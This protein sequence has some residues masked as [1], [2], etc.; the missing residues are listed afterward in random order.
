MDIQQKRKQYNRKKGIL[1]HMAKWLP[2]SVTY[3]IGGYVQKYYEPFRVGVLRYNKY[4]SFLNRSA[5]WDKD[6]IEAY[7]VKKLRDVLFFVQKHIPY[8]TKLFNQIGF[9]V[10]YIRSV[11]DLERIPLLTKDDIAQHRKSLMAD[12]LTQRE[13]KK[14]RLERSTSGST[15]TPL[16]IYSDKRFFYQR[17]AFVHWRLSRAGI[18]VNSRYI[19]LWS[20]P[21]IMSRSEELCIH[22]PY[23]GKLSLSSVPKS[24]EFY[25]GYLYWIK[26]F[27]PA[28]I[29]GP[30]SFMTS[31]A[32]YAKEKHFKDIHIPVFYS[33]YEMLYSYQENIIKEQ[34]GCEILRYY[35]CEERVVYAFECSYHEG[36]HV[37][38]RR[39]FVEIV[40][41]HGKVVPPGES[42]NLVCTSFD[43]YIMPFIR[44]KIGDIGVLSDEKCSCGLTLPLLKELHGR[45]SERIVVC[46]KTLFPATLSVVLEG[47]S[48]I[49]ECQFVKIGSEELRLYIVKRDGYNATDEIELTTRLKKLI[50][51]PLKCD[52][53]YRDFIARTTAGKFKL[54]I[55]QTKGCS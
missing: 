51:A 18:N 38:T 4:K 7:Q 50:G 49:K 9:D 13:I 5:Y 54:V 55:D 1:A 2:I 23:D 15:G 31:L 22:S 17:L 32:T 47:M 6:Q 52:F 29:V 36:L 41:N 53:V 35:S 44:Y 8:Y 43:N 30:P 16:T 42:G 11:R 48:N 14:W 33:C 39:S 3:G 24:H 21:F 20:R 45:T 12:C 34:F 27:K 28:Y 19:A 37:D 10:K 40:D 26:E 46:D 25:S